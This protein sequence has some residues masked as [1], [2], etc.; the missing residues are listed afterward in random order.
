VRGEAVPDFMSNLAA[1]GFFR[2]VDLELYEDQQKGEAAKFV[3]VCITN[4]KAPTE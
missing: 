4:T 2:T 1:T 3:L